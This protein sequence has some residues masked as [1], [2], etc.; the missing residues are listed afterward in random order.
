MPLALRK[1]SAKLRLVAY[2]FCALASD[3]LSLRDGSLKTDMLT[4]HNQTDHI[5]MNAAHETMEPAFGTIHCC[6][7]VPVLVKRA[8]HGRPSTCARRE[9]GGPV[10]D[11]NRP[12]V[13]LHYRSGW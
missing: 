13:E 10:V 8:P 1:P 11:Q 2:R 9:G 12:H 5:L 7:C 6:R 3:R 4:L